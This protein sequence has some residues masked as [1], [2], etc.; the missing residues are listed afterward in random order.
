MIYLR[1]VIL[2]PDKLLYSP[3]NCVQNAA[4]KSI[5][6]FKYIPDQPCMSGLNC[7]IVTSFALIDINFDAGP[8]LTYLHYVYIFDIYLLITMKMGYFIATSNKSF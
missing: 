5:S 1:N 4:H 3:R 6:S 7:C 2:Y 8:W